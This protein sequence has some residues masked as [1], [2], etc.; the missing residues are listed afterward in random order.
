MKIMLLISNIL[1]G[2]SILGLILL[3]TQ[4]RTESP[5]ATY[6][7]WLLIAALLIVQVLHFLTINQY[8]SLQGPEAS[9]YLLE[10]YMIAP[11]F[12]LFSRAVLD[13]QFRFQKEHLLQ[14]CLPLL[15]S[16]SYLIF[17]GLFKLFYLSAFLIGGVYMAVLAKL[18]LQLR[19][20]R[21]LFKTEFV[22]TGVFFAWALLIVLLGLAGFNNYLALMPY[23]NFMIACCVFIALYLQLNFPHLLTTLSDMVAQSY[24]NSTLNNV[25]CDEVKSRLEHLMRRKRLYEDDSL[26][27]SSLARNLN[28]STHQLSEFI[29]T[30]L[31]MG[32]SQYLRNIRVQAAKTYLI[33]QPHVSVLA[34]GMSV[35]F[36]S[37]SSF[38]SAFKELE[39]MAPGQYRKK[40]LP[41]RSGGSQGT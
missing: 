4:K 35:G 14:L 32:F 5:L 27:L 8:L 21:Q 37:Q 19:D 6:T 31:K 34:V 28:L 23:H 7:S 30:Q 17:P 40:K 9:L 16:L 29:N 10:L 11:S 36:T 39:G 1:F 33:E 3:V 18:L 38:Y 41:R 20:K 2:F 26:S 12:Y 15:V 13:S 24:Q 22:L 25:D